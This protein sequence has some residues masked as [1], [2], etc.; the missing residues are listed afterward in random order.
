MALRKLSATRAHVRYKLKDGS[1]CPGGSTISKIGEDQSFLISWAHK[2]GLDQQDYKK[3]V[4]RAADIGSVAH[5]LIECWL[6]GD[7]PDLQEYS[8]VAIDS[9]TQVFEKFKTTW[10]KENLSYVSSELELV[11]ETYRYGGTLDIV[12]RDKDKELVL[13][14]EKSSPQIYG[15]FY[16][17]LAGYENLWNENN[18]ERIRRRVIFRHGKD[19]PK[20][21]EVRWLDD[22]DK[23]FE[24]FKRQIDLYYAFRSI[25]KK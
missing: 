8:K 22:L 24:V 23:H 17:Q 11:S 1:I 2:L 5:F 19:N 12:A 14:D 15:S 21:T 9:G 7:D 4:D 13:V 25:N 10:N 20:D 18:E 6:K 16:R 3:V